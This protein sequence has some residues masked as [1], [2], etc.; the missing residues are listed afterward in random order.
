MVNKRA[1]VIFAITIGLQFIS[2]PAMIRRQVMKQSSNAS[3]GGHQARSL[4]TPKRDQLARRSFSWMKE[5]PRLSVS[6]IKEQVIK[7]FPLS[8][9]HNDHE[10][11]VKYDRLS[12][13]I[14]VQGHAYNKASNNLRSDTQEAAKFL[15]FGSLSAPLY[16]LMRFCES[17]DA[18]YFS[19]TEGFMDIAYMGSLGA[20]VVA[21]PVGLGFAASSFLRMKDKLKN[22]KR[23]EIEFNR[24]LFSALLKNPNI[25]IKNNGK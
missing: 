10:L 18:G 22:K 16:S 20:L 7:D 3:R 1:S 2:C 17:P 14:A 13:E 23:L 4:V 24:I 11:I 15:S 5:K 25:S 21:T 19:W 6:E 9:A 8:F 12:H